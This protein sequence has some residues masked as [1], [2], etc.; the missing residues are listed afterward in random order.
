MQ[1]NVVQDRAMMTEPTSAAIMRSHHELLETNPNVVVTR[2]TIPSKK[3]VVPQTTLY[4]V[5]SR[6]ARMLNAVLMPVTTTEH[7]YAV[8][9]L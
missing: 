4:R 5:M 2:L 6:E 9:T 1:E 7:I 8:T 3:F